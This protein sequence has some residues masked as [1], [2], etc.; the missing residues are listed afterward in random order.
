MA[1]IKISKSYKKK[2]WTD[3]WKLPVLIIFGV[4][5]FLSIL[6]L[7]SIRLSRTITE[8]SLDEYGCENIDLAITTGKCIRQSSGVMFARCYEV[9]NLYIY[10]KL[11]CMEGLNT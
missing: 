6:L 10:Y 2:K 9:E 8:Y 1:K 4:L 11:N 3:T 7:I 5:L